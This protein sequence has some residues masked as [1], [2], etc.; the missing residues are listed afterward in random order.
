MKYPCENC[1]CVA[2]CKHKPYNKL[3]RDCILLRSQLYDTNKVDTN[4]RTSDFFDIIIA[5][6]AILQPQCWGVEYSG[7]AVQ[8]RGYP[9][10]MPM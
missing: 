8:V 10:E 7:S 4:N 6:H 2:V 3:M 1:I 5:T 9:N